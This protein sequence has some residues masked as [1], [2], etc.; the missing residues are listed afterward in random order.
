MRERPSNVPFAWPE[1]AVLTLRSLWAEGY[2]C[3]HIA[4]EIGHGVTRNAVIGKARRLKLPQKTK[5]TRTKAQKAAAGR[6]VVRASRGSA[7]PLGARHKPKPQ[8]E[9]PPFETSPLPEEE[10]GNDVTALVG[11][12]RDEYRLNK[13]CAYGLGDPRTENFRF[14]GDPLHAGSHWCERH[15][16]I[17]YPGAQS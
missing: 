9:S 17:V 14:C 1:N 3:A 10:L 4:K 7:N 6:A 16:H 13:H 8:M 12:T 15:Y 2:S 5:T 11:V